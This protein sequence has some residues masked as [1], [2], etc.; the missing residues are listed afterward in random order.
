[1]EQAPWEAR[2]DAWSKAQLMEW[3][4]YA[5]E[6]G[7]E[8]IPEVRLLTHQNRFFMKQHPDLMFNKS[9]Y[10]PRKEDTY[11]RVFAILDEVIQVIHP[12]AIH[13]G[14]DEVAGHSS[15][16]R[17]KWLRAGEE[18]LPADLFLRDVLRIHDYLKKRGIE[19]W[20][21]GDMLISP[22]EFPGMLAKHLHGTGPGYG[23]ALRDKLPRDIVIC[24]WHYLDSQSD[25]PSLATMKQEG[26]R[27]IGVTWK[28]KETIRNFSRYAAQH[29]AYGMMATI[30]FYVPRRKWDVVD[31]IIR[32]S[33]E[34]FLKDFPDAK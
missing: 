25:F 9:T 12:K 33:G 26:F 11:Q 28:K 15:R 8:V 5:Y 16:S 13:I 4:G 30:W 18:M 10:D 14:H 23:K 19:T 2:K 17:E 1:M 34:V 7:L 24:D 22:A 20:M 27:V 29:G 32:T 31:I 3:V 6:K 21:W